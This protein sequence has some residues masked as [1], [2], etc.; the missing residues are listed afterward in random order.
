MK[1]FSIIVIILIISST[2]IRA[3]TPLTSRVEDLERDVEFA[4]KRS[5]KQDMLEVFNDTGFMNLAER[6]ELKLDK[7][8]TVLA[9]GNELMRSMIHRIEEK[10]KKDNEQDKL[11]RSNQTQGVNN[12]SRIWAIISI[13]SVIFGLLG[14]TIKESIKARKEAQEARE[15]NKKMEKDVIIYTR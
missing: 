8:N 9:E 6:V 10:E 14:F 1:R 5:A 11:I 2:G 12:A 13:L 4:L 15:V 3:E 7:S